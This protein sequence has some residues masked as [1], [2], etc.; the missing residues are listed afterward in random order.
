[1]RGFTSWMFLCS[2]AANSV[3][4]WAEM[5]WLVFGKTSGR[6]QPTNLHADPKKSSK[7]CFRFITWAYLS[8]LVY[9]LFV[10]NYSGLLFLEEHN[11]GQT[12]PPSIK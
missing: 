4:V 9:L 2:L 6:Q 11:L 3:S 5:G 1:M 7:S 10:S 12:P 8:L